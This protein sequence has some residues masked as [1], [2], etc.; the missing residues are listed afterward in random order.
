MLPTKADIEQYRGT[1]VEGHFDDMG[2]QHQFV[3]GDAVYRADSG[4]V[5]QGHVMRIER[6][7]L[8]SQG[9]KIGPAP[10]GKYIETTAR[11]GYSSYDSQTYCW[12]FFPR[13]ETAM[14]KLAEQQLSRI[15]EL[16]R[17]IAKARALIEQA[18]AGSAPIR[19]Y[20]RNGRIIPAD[21]QS[22]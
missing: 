14:D 1:S 18:K 3:I 19:R 15:Q 16:E 22:G 5:E 10:D 17:D 4:V 9:R 7:N 11:F 13:L 8:D 6:V 12:R 20:D 2:G 21:K